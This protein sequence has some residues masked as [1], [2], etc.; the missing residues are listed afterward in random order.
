MR[1]LTNLMRRFR[2][3]DSGANKEKEMSHAWRNAPEWAKD[4]FEI[5]YVIMV[6]NEAILAKLEDRSAQYSSREKR[7][8][9]EIVKTL[10]STNKK[11]DDAR[12]DTSAA[13]GGP[14]EKRR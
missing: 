3:I 4:L 12:K 2:R 9:E 8:L 11:I 10:T 6:Q 7:V 13:P 5:Q 1:C 14:P